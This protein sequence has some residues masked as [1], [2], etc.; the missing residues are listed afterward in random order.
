M[1]QS[2]FQHIFYF[3]GKKN[4]KFNFFFVEVKRSILKY[5]FMSCSTGPS[6]EDVE[7]FY[8]DVFNGGRFLTRQN[9]PRLGGVSKCPI[10]RYNIQNASSAKEV[11]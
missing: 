7:N 1:N 5:L 3:A 8:I 10:E 6:N 2:I 9:C 11:N 4:S